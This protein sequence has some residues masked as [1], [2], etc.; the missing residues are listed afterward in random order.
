MAVLDHHGLEERL[1]QAI[2]L[3]RV[4][5]LPGVSGIEY[6]LLQPLQSVGASVD[7]GLDQVSSLGLQLGPPRLVVALRKI[8]HDEE[9][10]QPAELTFDRLALPLSLGSFWAGLVVRI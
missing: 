6:V 4:G 2:P 8:A 1:R 5:I 7:V 10:A 3:G 9:V